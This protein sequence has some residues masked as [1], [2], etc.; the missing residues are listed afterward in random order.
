[1]GFFNF[2]EKLITEHGSAAIGEKRIAL[3]KEEAAAL[4]LKLEDAQA[5]INLLELEAAKSGVRKKDSQMKLEEAQ[6]EIKRLNQQGEAAKKLTTEDM[7]A[8]LAL[9]IPPGM[10]CFGANGLNPNCNK[11]ARNQPT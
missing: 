9:W 6:A 7:D 2:I 4:D 11:K 1:M 5:R 10:A 8:L 3:L